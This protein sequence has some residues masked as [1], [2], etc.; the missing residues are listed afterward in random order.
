MKKIPVLPESSHRNL[1]LHT[2]HCFR[3]FSLAGIR[4][5]TTRT[6]FNHQRDYLNRAVSEVWREEQEHLLEDIQK[7]GEKLS[8]AGDARCDSMGHRYTFTS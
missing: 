1:L 4:V 6:L 3:I 8:V 5:P 2:I 7:S